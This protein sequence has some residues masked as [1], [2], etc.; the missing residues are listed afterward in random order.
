MKIRSIALTVICSLLNVTIIFSQE[1]VATSPDSNLKVKVLTD[2]GTPYYTVT[3]KGKT[4]LENS[5]LES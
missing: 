5:P 4:F 2:D 1:A 3:Y